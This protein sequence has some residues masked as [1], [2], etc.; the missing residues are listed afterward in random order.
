MNA[1]NKYLVVHKL[2]YGGYLVV[3]TYCNNAFSSGSL[4]D[5][6]R[7]CGSDYC[8]QLRTLVTFEATNRI[9]SF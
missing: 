5:A 7:P 6:L 1:C 2:E 8:S 3:G 4:A 9:L